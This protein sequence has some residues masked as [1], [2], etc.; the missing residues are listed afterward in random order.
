MRFS[1]Y[2]SPKEQGCECTRDLFLYEVEHP[3]LAER[4]KR[5]RQL[6]AQGKGEEAS[7]CKRALPCVTWQALSTDGSH[8][9]ASMVP[10][11]L[12]MLDVDHVDDPISAWLQAMSRICGRDF[13]DLAAYKAA[14]DDPLVKAALEQVGI[15]VCH[16]SPSGHGIRVV[17]QRRNLSLATIAEN[18]AWLADQLGIVAYDGACTDYSRLAFLCPREDF[19]YLNLKLWDM[20]DNHPFEPTAKMSTSEVQRSAAIGEVTA[21]G[22]AP[23][24]NGQQER[25]YTDEVKEFQYNGHSITEIARVWVEQH[26][27]PRPGERNN[28]YHAMVK[29]FRNI[30]DDNVAIMLC[31]LP[32][33]GLPVGE[34]EKVINQVIK[35]IG[36]GEIP[37]HF[38]KFLV[39]NGFLPDTTGT[40]L[41][42]E[43]SSKAAEEKK[44][45]DE[46]A[47]AVQEPPKPKRS[48]LFP[49]LPPVF[50]EFCSL[51]P[52]EFV[53]PTI[54]A[55]LPVLG[56]L[57]TRLRATYIDGRVQTTSFIGVIFAP[58][59]SGKS[60][61]RDVVTLCTKDLVAHD[62]MS[63]AKEK[64]W[65]R[66]M[67]T[68][69][70]SEN[71]PEEPHAPYRM[72]QSVISVPRLLERQEDACGLHQFSF[73]E[74]IDTL[75][76]SNSGGSYAQKSDL[77]RQ[78]FDN[79][80]YGQDYMSIDTFSGS[81]N[82]YYNILMLGTNNQLYEFF[83]DA[84]NGL[85]SRCCFAE[86]EGQEFAK[87]PF[88]R[89]LTPKQME[90]ITAVLNRFEAMTYTRKNAM[91]D[92]YI[93]NPEVNLDAQMGFIRTALNKWLEKER[94]VS[95]KE[96]N[97]SRDIFRRRSAVK[98]FRLAMICVGMFDNMTP[99]RQK[100]IEQF[101]LWFADKDLYH[102]EKAFGEMLR[103][104]T[105][106][107][108]KDAVLTA[109]LFDE[110]QEQF[111][112]EDLAEV[113]RRNG[114]TGKTTYYTNI[115]SKAGLIR[116]TSWTTFVK[117][118]TKTKTKTA[119]RS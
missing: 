52:E 3:R 85:V 71:P 104:Q 5:I 21:S 116:K 103:K 37:Y 32:G 101:V 90:A 46:A 16:V 35:R 75:K 97:I 34:R 40:I 78:A 22:G 111:S 91:S 95:M 50:K 112:N 106:G 84:E 17:A 58:P 28:Y 73:T 11:S 24:G 107:K 9:E 63:L 69:R 99:A 60:F 8:R 53:Y 48:E 79:A 47:V 54:V 10:N 14:L 74:E 42:Q 15:L 115:W 1:V 51:Y 105:T 119:P 4:V 83:N 76:K 25:D 72:V 59:A 19:L 93:V 55:L 86:I 7:Q 33:F 80:E 2:R 66:E 88:F 114:R 118:K 110:L 20:P 29:L 89:S 108:R 65:K 68:K 36:P 57:A 98:A 117:T 30:T 56:T 94:L 31:Q 77:Y 23:T 64:L 70:N 13:P 44:S 87:I 38:Y 102:I 113:L 27:E 67:K 6:I 82:L 18:Q 45:A 43:E 41:Q 100:L 39:K 81:V 62:K 61:A 92:E 49:P 12:Y 26:G 109:N 96:G